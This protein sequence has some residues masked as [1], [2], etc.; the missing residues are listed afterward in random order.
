[1]SSSSMRYTKE[2][3][4]WRISTHELGAVRKR[5]ILEPLTILLSPF[6][7]HICEE[8]WQTALGH[9]QTIFDASYP[10]FDDKYLVESTFEYPVSVNGKLRFKLELPLGIPNTE[11]EAAALADQ[12][13]AKFLAGTT[14]KKV[15]VVPGKI[16]NIVI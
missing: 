8:L 11:I 4:P 3:M 10:D 14:P 1:M 2:Y 16:I 9:S 6:A 12:N 15:V 7:P 13:T 5:A